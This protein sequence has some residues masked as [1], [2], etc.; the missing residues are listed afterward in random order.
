MTAPAQIMTEEPSVSME[1]LDNFKEFS[2]LLERALLSG[3]RVVI[4][5]QGK[6]MGAIVPWEDVEILRALEDRVDGEA[7]AEA[8]KEP[9]VL[10]LEEVE[11]DLGL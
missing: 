4:T 6:P 8:L 11:R 2:L 3:E 1:L 7:A 9:G 10:S 5:R